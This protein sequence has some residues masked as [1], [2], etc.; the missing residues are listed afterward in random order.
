MK[1]P[2]VQRDNAG[3][4]GSSCSGNLQPELSDL[5]AIKISDSFACMRAVGTAFPERI[6]VLILGK[7]LENTVG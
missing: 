6:A 2:I 4:R 3:E 5:C 7:R 1:D